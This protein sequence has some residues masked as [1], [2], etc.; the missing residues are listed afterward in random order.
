MTIPQ[1]FRPSIPDAR[2]LPEIFS[3][4]VALTPQAV[5]YRQFDRAAN[6]WFDWT[7]R[8]M[9][10]EVERWRKALGKEQLAPGARVATIMKHGVD[11]IAVDQAA[12]SLGLVIVPLHATD[13]PGNVGY[14]VHDCGASILVIDSADYW[15]R[16][17][18]E[19]GAGTDL[20]RVVIL[21]HEGPGRQR[22][23]ET[24]ARAVAASEW[25]ALAA[26]NVA[27]EVY[28]SPEMLATIVYTS[29]TTGRPKGVMLSQANV[30]SNVLAVLQCVAPNGEDLFLSFLPISHT[31]ERTAGYYL[32]IASGST[33]AFARSSALLSEDLRT[34]RPTVLISVPR[35]YER[36]RLHIE[37]KV[38][39][40]GAFRQAIFTLAERLGWRQFLATQCDASVQLSVAE[41]FVWIFLDRFVAAK[42][43]AEFG[44]RLRIAVAGGAPLPES[45]SKCFLAMGVN[46]VQ[47]YG[48]T[49]TAPVVSVNRSERNDPATVGEVISGVEVRIGDNDELLVKGPNVMLGYWR[50]A[51]ETRRVLEPDGWLHTGDQAQF[52]KGRLKIKGRLKD[53]IV[54]STGEKI[55]PSDLEQAIAVDV[56]FEQAM[57]I[58]E[59]RPFIAALAVLNRAEVEREAKA[60]GLVGEM[61]DILASDA[62]RA[63]VLKRIERAVAQFPKYATPRKVWLTVDPWTVG[64][65]LMTPTLK[66]KRLAIEMAF[67][68][69]IT[70]LY[71]R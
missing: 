17:A 45:A 69:E 4:R 61:N 1:P 27:P 33:V 9:R 18:P 24:D 63:F 6:E 70:S 19:V 5:A 54:T 58:G 11:Y 23:N 29:G 47:G 42:I 46:I 39:K 40:G 26:T 13:N 2:T 44:G 57:V 53:I 34:I 38:A 65:G 64:A 3:A 49:E 14:I 32:P 25:L 15:T 31:F 16:L 51:E 55:S 67:D 56:L 59:Q 43:R 35:I 60:L 21:S 52:D 71:S 22:S 36:F 37:E 30:V 66:L 62:F 41:R 48:M 12:L 50:R 20:K 68:R 28:V 8:E 10:D 7:W